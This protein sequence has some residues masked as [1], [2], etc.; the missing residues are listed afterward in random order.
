MFIAWAQAKNNMAHRVA[1]VGIK[2]TTVPILHMQFFRTLPCHYEA[3][4]YLESRH[5]T[6]TLSPLFC[7]CQH[8]LFMCQHYCLHILCLLPYKRFTFRQRDGIVQK[9]VL[10]SDRY[11]NLCTSK[12]SSKQ[13]LN[14]AFNFV[15]KLTRT[16]N[17]LPDEASLIKGP[18]KWYC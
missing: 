11:L 16:E 13:E 6:L 3:K 14:L 10:P 8:G 9:I 7:W 18:Q 15:M 1:S 4:L 5:T 17:D 2:F 12:I